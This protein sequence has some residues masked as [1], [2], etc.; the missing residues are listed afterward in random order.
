MTDPSARPEPVVRA[1]GLTRT[2]ADGVGVHD[3]DL[4]VEQGTIFGFIGPSGSGKTTSIR[5]MTGILAPESGE[6]TVFGKAPVDFDQADRGRL[7]YMPQLSVLYPHLSIWENLGFS[8]SLFGMRWRGRRPRMRDQLQLVELD[9]ARGRLLRDSSGGMQ[10]RLALAA[11]LIHNPDL[12]FL[13]E[14][15]AG[16]DPILRKKVWDH[17]IHL[18][19]EGRTLFIT[20]QYVGEAAYCDRVGILAEGRLIA[21]DTPEGLRRQAFGG[22]VL[23]VRFARPLLAPQLDQL[24]EVSSALRAERIG[25]HEVRLVV[26]DA[27]E[28]SPQ[29]T[30]WATEA[31]VEVESVE[32]YLPAFDDVFVE[33]V[34]KLTRNGVSES[35]SRSGSL[36]ET[37]TNP[38]GSEPEELTPD[39]LTGAGK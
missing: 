27:G 39:A 5:L 26:A 31:N 19:E 23:D 15:T 22:E 29:V 17:F 7:G 9:E 16:I 38:A 34:S 33:L 6:L 32:P 8:A 18:R 21:V 24:I 14:P 37:R 1:R 30:A 36:E 10:R 25:S 13:D 11:T 20:T 35:E 2:F 3:L 12:L 4:D 28:V